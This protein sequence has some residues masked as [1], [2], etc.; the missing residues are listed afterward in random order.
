MPAHT[1]ALALFFYKKTSKGDGH[2]RAGAQSAET[3][4]RPNPITPAGKSLATP[5]DTKTPGRLQ[6]NARAF[7]IAK[8]KT[9]YSAALTT[10]RVCDSW[11][12]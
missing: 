5:V 12:L 4:A 3:C 7:C 6:C 8:L 10:R 11:L 9:N 1:L 2:E